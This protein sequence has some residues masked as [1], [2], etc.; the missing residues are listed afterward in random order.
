MTRAGAP[1]RFLPAERGRWN[2]VYQRFAR[3][4]ERGVWQMLLA[5]QAEDADLEWLM[6]G[7]TVVRA[8]ASAA[9]AKRGKAI[10]R[11]GGHGAGSRA[12]C[13]RSPT[14]SATPCASP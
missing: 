9:G 4:Q 2:S 5:A 11:P 10:R 13:T 14:V 7:S 12:S 8:H 6:P 3:W 1:W